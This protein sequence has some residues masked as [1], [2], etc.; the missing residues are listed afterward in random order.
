MTFQNE[1]VERDVRKLAESIGAQCIELDVQDDAMLTAAVGKAAATLG[2]IDTLVHAVAFAPADELGGRYVDTSRE[3]FRLALEISAYSLTALAKA[4]EPHM[5]GR[6]GGGSI[7]TLTYIASDRA[8][9]GYN[10]MGVAK[11]AL[12]S[13]VRYLAW[14]LGAAGIRVNAISAGPIRTLAAR[15]IPGFSTM[16][17]SA[18]ERTPLRREVTAQDVAGVAAFLASPASAGVT[19]EVIFAD[20][21]FHA[22]GL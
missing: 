2:G 21:G 15:G 20:A 5:T 13:M 16:A 12:E 9:P 6:P 3:G 4:V 22:V 18:A 7:M 11:A 10:V 1:R 19:G 8:M 14:D 17:E